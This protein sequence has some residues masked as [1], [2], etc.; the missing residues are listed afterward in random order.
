MTGET[1]LPEDGVKP[2]LGAGALLSPAS[3]VQETEQQEGLGVGVSE[4]RLELMCYPGQSHA[5]TGV[6]TW[7]GHGQGTLLG[8]G[9]GTWLGHGQGTP[10]S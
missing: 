2:V 5:A 10:C 4:G 6:E 7:L 3:S 1:E 9:Q 8:H